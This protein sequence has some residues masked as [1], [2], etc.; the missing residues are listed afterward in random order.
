V[1][2]DRAFVLL[3][4]GMRDLHIS[5]VQAS[6]ARHETQL[7]VD[8]AT[9]GDDLSDLARSMGRDRSRTIAHD[10]ADGTLGLT[11]SA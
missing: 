2:C 9:A 11:R 5:Y 10:V 6:R 8:R 4:D 3:D 7:F 1:T